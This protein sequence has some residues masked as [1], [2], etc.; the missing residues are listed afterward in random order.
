MLTDIDREEIATQIDTERIAGLSATAKADE[1]QAA[2]DGVL[3]ESVRIRSGLE[4]QED[5]DA[6]KKAQDFYNAGI[7]D[8]EIKYK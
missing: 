4:I 1:K 7:A 3:A 5:S 6:L 8:V 2:I